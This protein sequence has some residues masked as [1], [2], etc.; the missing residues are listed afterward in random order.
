MKHYLL[1]TSVLCMVATMTMAQNPIICDQY[2]ADPTARVFILP[3]LLLAYLIIRC[4]CIPRMTLPH[5]LVS[6]R[7]GSAW[8]IIMYFL[9]A[10]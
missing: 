7:I 2:T 8:R 9:P 6:D 4:T 5:P 3:T 1:S 10:T